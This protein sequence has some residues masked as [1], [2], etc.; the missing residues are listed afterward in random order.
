MPEVICE[1]CGY[2]WEIMSTRKPQTLCVSCRAKRVQTVQNVRGK[3]YPW[4]GH[5]AA[6]MVTPIHEDGSPVIIGKRICGN[7][8]CV[9]PSHSERKAN[10]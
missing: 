6:D 2:K 3:C 1:R 9:N 10:G 5:Y 7:N 8:D 4:H